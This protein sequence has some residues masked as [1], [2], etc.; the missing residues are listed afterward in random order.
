M[1]AAVLFISA[2]L[3]VLSFGLAED[4]R[5]EQGQ[6]FEGGLFYI[7]GFFGLAYPEDLQ[8]VRGQ[9]FG[10]PL[11]DRKVDNVLFREPDIIYGGKIGFIPEEEYTWI[12]VE[13]EYFVTSTKLLPVAGGRVK[14]TLEVR[15]L[16]LN[17]L[18][19]Y[20]RSWVQPYIGAGPSLIQAD[21][22]QLAGKG[23]TETSIGLNLLA[24]VRVPI[25][26]RLMLFAEAK[27][28]RVGLDFA[29]LNFEYSLT[30]AVGG[31]GIMF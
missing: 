5:A 12:G 9:P 14:G 24:G 15:A 23:T 6:D 27:H 25:A 31:V 29:L 4:A 11:A 20:P 2:L 13:A 17:F 8:Q 30:A 3:L 18:L 7:A 26:D 19:R 16:S 28:L 21:S 22:F 10:T 1:K